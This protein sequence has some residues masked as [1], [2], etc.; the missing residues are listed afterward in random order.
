VNAR[1]PLGDLVL[2][3]VHRARGRVEAPVPDLHRAK[4]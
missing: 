4:G 3:L 2:P 1:E